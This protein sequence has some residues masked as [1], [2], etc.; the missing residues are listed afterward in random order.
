MDLDVNVL[1]QHYITELSNM[2]QRALIAE[3]RIEQLETELAQ[4][5]SGDTDGG[6]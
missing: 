1:V 4:L 2:L 6:N 5:K 3:S